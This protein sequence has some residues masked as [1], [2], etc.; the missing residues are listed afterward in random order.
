MERENSYVEERRQRTEPNERAEL[1]PASARVRR[2]MIVL[3]AIVATM[4]FLEIVDV[5]LLQQRL[6]ALGVR[7]RTGTGLWGILFMPLLHGSLAHVAANTLPFLVLGWLVI[8]RRLSD[9][10]VVTAVVMIVSGTGVW[11]FGAGSTVSIGASG[12]VFGYFGYLLLRG[13]FERS[14]SSIL[15]AALVLLFYGGMFWGV[16]PQGAGISWEA[17]L[18]GFAGGVLAAWLLARR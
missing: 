14:A 6:N 9:F 3:G 10:L 8:M 2:R 7:P 13:Y 11:L 5:L 15:I 1:V 4:W 17:H 18:F 12:L 16:L